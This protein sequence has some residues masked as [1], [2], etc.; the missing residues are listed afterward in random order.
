MSK[1]RSFNFNDPRAIRSELK[2][3]QSAFWSRLGVTQSGGSRYE[4]GRDLP[5][6]VAKLASLAFADA[7]QALAELAALRQT[8]VAELVA[9]GS[10]P[11]GQTH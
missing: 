2:L 10:Q 1:K 7:D 6:P 9:A 5:K 3:N 4:S 11:V 8:T